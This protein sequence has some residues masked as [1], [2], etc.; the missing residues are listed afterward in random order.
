MC[1]NCSAKRYHSRTKAEK[2][3]CAH[4]GFRDAGSLVSID[5]YPFL[6]TPVLVHVGVLP[7]SMADDEYDR[8][9][10]LINAACRKPFSALAYVAPCLH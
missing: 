9:V 6:P 8:T 3:L 1:K 7:C 4:L 5:P 10:V 2:K